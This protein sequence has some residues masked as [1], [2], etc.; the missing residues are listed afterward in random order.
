MPS[1][2]T[3]SAS[4]TGGVPSRRRR[5]CDRDGRGAYGT[6]GGLGGRAAA[7]HRRGARRAQDIA[8]GG[9]FGLWRVL[10]DVSWWLIHK[11]LQCFYS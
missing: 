3:F 8:R 10:V 1:F 5:R 4:T 9:V 7:A 2:P 6:Q 11:L